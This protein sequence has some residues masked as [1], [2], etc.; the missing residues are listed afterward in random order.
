MRKRSQQTA[1]FIRAPLELLEAVP[2]T[3]NKAQTKA[4]KTPTQVTVKKTYH[5]NGGGGKIRRLGED[6]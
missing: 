6:S 1:I 4:N 2:V 5:K 3:D